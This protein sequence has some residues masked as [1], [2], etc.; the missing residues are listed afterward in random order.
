VRGGEGEGRVRVRGKKEEKEE[1]RQTA[2]S[3]R[4]KNGSSDRETTTQ[5]GQRYRAG[6]E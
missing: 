5:R 1:E 3:W 4:V 2:V 6:Y